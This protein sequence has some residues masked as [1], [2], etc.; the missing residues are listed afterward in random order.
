MLPFACCVLMLGAESVPEAPPP[1]PYQLVV[2][3]RVADHPLL[4]STFVESV[5]KEVRDQMRSLF[6]PLATVDV[7]TRGHWLLDES[8]GREIEHPELG[9]EN[10]GKLAA[11]ERAFLFTLDYRANVY[12]LA[13]RQLDPVHRSQTPPGF[14]ETPD[15]QW[16]ARAICLAIKADFSLVAKIEPNNDSSAATLTCLGDQHATWLDRLLG[17]QGT[18]EVYEVVKLRNGTAERRMVS[19]TLL[20]W[21]RQPGALRASVESHAKEPFKKRANTIGFEAVRLPTRQ[22]RIKLQLVDERTGA[23]LANCT[24]YANDQGFGQFTDE[25]I[26]ARPDRGGFVVSPRDFKNVAYV[27]VSQGNWDRRQLPIPLVDAVTTRV[28][29]LPGDPQAFAKS[30]LERRLRF[31]HQDLAF[32][33]GQQDGVVRET[34]QM[35][36]ERRYEDLLQRWE[37][38]QSLVQPRFETLQLELGKLRQ[39]AENLKMAAS[40]QLDAVA[41]DHKR[42]EE[43]HQQLGRLRTATEGEMKVRDANARAKRQIEV[44]SAAKL[45]GDYD[46]VIARL[47]LAL[48]EQPDLPQVK[49]DLARIKAKWAIR[50]ES[51][52]AAR[53]FVQET[54]QAADNPQLEGLVDQADKNLA[55]FQRVDDWLTCQRFVRITETHI[56]NITALIDDLTAR[57]APEDA[58][59]KDKF[60]KLLDRLA[61]LQEKYGGFVQQGMAAEPRS[62]SAPEGAPASPTPPPSTPAAPPVTPPVVPPAAA[63]Q[64]EEPPAKRP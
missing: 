37:E 9:T 26:L 60:V 28:I 18:W 51:H 35:N 55:V 23:P 12:R 49:Q 10:W 32:V 41:R 61:D 42:L 46:E 57:G 43:R 7:V 36:E 27:R 56:E 38:Y 39:E 29:R 50:D 14:R 20:L 11:A 17:D 24:V 25:D 1:T 19:N 54:W 64:E 6:G 5:R 3:L 8:R 2:C 58:A 47:E 4:T 53:Q 21:R 30:D 34:N 44:A 52:R 22:G 16:V 15:R 48:G 33:R 59:E 40:D 31:L 62:G 13:W 63:D 45:V